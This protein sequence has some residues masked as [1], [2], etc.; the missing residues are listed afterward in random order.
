MNLKNIKVEFNSNI[1][2]GHT[3]WATHGVINEVNT[4]PHLNNNGDIAIVHN[5]VIDNYLELK[6]FLKDYQFKSD[7]DTEVI[8][9]LL[10]INKNG[11]NM[12][13][14][15]KTIN[16]LEGTFALIISFLDEPETL[17][18]T[19]RGS[20]LLLSYT[21]NIALITS[22]ESGFNGLVKNH[23]RLD[24]NDIYK[25]VKKD[26]I[27]ISNNLDKEYKFIKNN[28][29]KN[30][31]N[32]EPYHNWTEKEIFKQGE[33]ILKCL[34]NGS[35]IFNNEE[36]I[37]GGLN[38]YNDKLKEVDNLIILGWWIILLCIFIG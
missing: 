33:S 6:E 21:D 28:N 38:E 36:V 35:R 26:K 10:D 32:F 23:I 17:Y 8:A 37:L 13:R 20:P 9:N 30:D 4:H 24:N 2:I 11:S 19:K 25:I 29:Y 31:L 18:I 15:Q 14:I 1:G 5:G 27:T 12:K 34:N 16:M 7:T 22:E 3:R